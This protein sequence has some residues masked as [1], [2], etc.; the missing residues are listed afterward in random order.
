MLDVKYCTQN[1]RTS[2]PASG[3]S[4]FPASGSQAGGPGQGPSRDVLVLAQVGRRGYVTP[5]RRGPRRAGGRPDAA[6]GRT[7]QKGGGAGRRACALI[8][9]AVAILAMELELRPNPSGMSRD[10]T[11]RR[12]CS[13]FCGPRS[14]LTWRFSNFMSHVLLRRSYCPG[15]RACVLKLQRHFQSCAFYRENCEI[16]PATK[17]TEPEGKGEKVVHRAPTEGADSFPVK[18]NVSVDAPEP[19]RAAA[20]LSLPCRRGSGYGRP[21]LSLSKIEPGEEGGV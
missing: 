18:C 3:P 16:L 17:S 2:L 20:S 12:V 14:E 10:V 13:Y 6:G 19:R 11:N 8:T 7:D 4:C 15:H 21:T 9:C 5:V 1:A